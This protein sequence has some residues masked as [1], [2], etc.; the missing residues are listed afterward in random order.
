MNNQSSE[1]PEQPPIES[2][3]DNAINAPKLFFEASIA[4]SSDNFRSSGLILTKE[5]I[6]GLKK[7]ELV[8]LSL[9]VELEAVISYL[10]YSE[11]AGPGLEP[12]DFQNSFKLIRTH[13][14]RWRPLQ[15]KLRAIGSELKLFA[16]QMSIYGTSMSNLI[17]DIKSGQL[18]DA[19]NIQ[20]VADLNRVRLEMGEHYPGIELTDEERDDVRYILDKIISQVTVKHQNAEEIKRELDEFGRDLAYHVLPEVQRKII[21]IDNNSLPQDI[22]VLTAD[23]E[24]RAA[25][26]DEKNKEYKQAVEQSLSSVGKLNVV[27]LALGIYFG[28]EA[29]NVR[30]ARNELMATQAIEIELLHSKNR[31]LGSLS[32]VRFDLQNL[33]TIVI[34]ADIATKNLI[35]VWNSIALYAEQSQ[36]TTG[37]ITDALKLKW[38]ISEFS[39]VVSP[40]KNIEQDAEKLLDVFKQADHEFKRINGQ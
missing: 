22:S 1:I 6:I 38:F 16:G 37:N 29:E 20:T 35:T 19:N 31:I 36:A 3:L 12:R 24:R 15:Q 17:K 21:A 32:R 18:V 28:V 26:I 13:A 7:Y 8:G 33:S 23:I 5:Q 25:D 30:A 34:D 9:P 2:T 4:G 11:G 40:W 27:G 14:S 39:L 10:G